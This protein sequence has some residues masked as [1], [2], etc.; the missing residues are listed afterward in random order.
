MGK[1]SLWVDWNIP[2]LKRNPCA[3]TKNWMLAWTWQSHWAGVIQCFFCQTGVFM[4]W[5]VPVWN[6]SN[7]H[8]QLIVFW[9]WME[10][11]CHLRWFNLLPE[12]RSLSPA[13]ASA[14]RILK[15]K[16]SE[17][18]CLQIKWDKINNNKFFYQLG[19]LGEYIIPDPT[20]DYNCVFKIILSSL[21][22]MP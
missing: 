19:I 16:W 4:T 3:T 13:G 22:A 12:F 11:K 18:P 2:S 5:Q 8:R 15:K 20:H 14:M 9:P 6:S 1:V 10:K 21:R 7:S 17:K